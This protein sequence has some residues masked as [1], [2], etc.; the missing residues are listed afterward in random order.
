MLAATFLNISPE[1]YASSDFSQTLRAFI[2]C[3]VKR[4][5]DKLKALSEF[6]SAYRDM[7]KNLVVIIEPM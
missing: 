5:N 6:P 4:S 7:G 3:I 2:S 1:N